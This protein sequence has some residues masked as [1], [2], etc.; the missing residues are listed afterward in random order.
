M[1]IYKQLTIAGAIAMALVSNSV[2]AG[3]VVGGNMT[4]FSAGTPAVAADVN[5]NFTEHTTQ[6]NDN[7]AS[8]PIMWANSDTGTGGTTITAAAAAETNSVAITAPSAGFVVISGYTFINPTTLTHYALRPYIDGATVEQAQA[9]TETSGDNFA[10]SY[11]YTAPITAGA[12][13]ISQTVGPQTGTGTFFYNRNHLTVVFYPASNGAIPLP[14]LGS[15]A[16][17]GVSG[18]D[19]GLDANGN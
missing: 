19:M 9:I 12:H 6:I 15:S 16:G 5:G 7:A 17:K 11:T 1:N 2:F 13:T 8:L 18:A 10:I 14:E 4:T 3:T